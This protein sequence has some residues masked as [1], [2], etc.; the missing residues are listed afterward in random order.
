MYKC[1]VVASLLAAK[2]KLLDG[3]YKSDL[4]RRHSVKVLSGVLQTL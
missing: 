2:L 4:F 1:Q 3:V